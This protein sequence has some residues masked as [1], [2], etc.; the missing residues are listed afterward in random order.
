MI[1]REDFPFFKNNPEIIYLDSACTSIKPKQVID[2]QKEYY[3]KLGACAARSS[4]KKGRETSLKIE[5]SRETIAKFVNG[6]ADG[7]VFTKNTTEGLNIV[8]NGLD[9]SMKNKVV[10]TDLEHHAVLLPLMKMR[11]KGRIKLEIIESENG[12]I[13][14]EKWKNAIDNQT[15]LVVTNSATNTTGIFQ[16]LEL[17]SKIA[18]EKESYLLVDGAQGVPHSKTDMKK[19]NI[20]FLCF[21]AHKMLGPNGVGA[22]LMKKEL[23][24]EVEELS[25]GGGTVTK[26]TKQ[27]Y[28]LVQDQSRFEA[29]VGDYAGI[30]GFAKACEYLGKIDYSKRLEHEE[31]LR[32]ALLETLKNNNAQILGDLNAKRGALYTFNIKGAKAHDLALMLDQENIAVRSGFFCAQPALSALGSKEGAVRVSAYIYNNIEEIRKFAEKLEKISAIYS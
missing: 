14:P 2:A 4:H 13:S 29:G 19:A 21:S 5:E 6:D 10:T 25:I 15:R 26:V 27:N 3:E 24:K 18:H 30:I 11:D 32:A 1:N 23:V 22:L 16:N 7:V 8:I 20:D 9:Y 31:K 17:I 12:L 28:D